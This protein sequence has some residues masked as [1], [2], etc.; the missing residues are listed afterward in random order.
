MMGMGRVCGGMGETGE[1]REG[2]IVVC[3]SGGVGVLIIL[4]GEKREGE[5]DGDGGGGEIG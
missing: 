2:E 3:V 1:G 5:K 4:V